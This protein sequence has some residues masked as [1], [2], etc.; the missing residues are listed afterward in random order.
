MNYRHIYH[1]GNFADVFKHWILTCVLQKILE[2]ETPCC[3]IDTHAGIGWYDT[4]S[5]E[6]QKTQEA[7]HGVNKILQQSQVADQFLDYLNIVKTY[8]QQYNA[9]PGSPAI[10]QEF[11][12]GSDRLL[13]NEMHAE[14]YATLKA[15][16]AMNRQI[17]IF[18]QD[19]Y[20]TLKAILPPIE[21]RAVIFIDPPFEKTNEWDLIIQG[22]KQ[23]L[24][25]FANGIYM[26]WYPIKDRNVVNKFYKNIHN[27]A[28]AKVLCVELHLNENIG[29][30]LTACGL[31]IFNTP[32]QLKETLNEYMPKLLKYLQ[33]QNAR[34]SLAD[35]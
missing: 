6:A 10:M 16:F 1:A 3:L 14:D 34:F 19:A 35:L 15:N 17:K 13:L 31:I 27:L 8:A 5:P 20:A 9:Y 18:N 23:A 29:S 21:R 33:F 11:L 7:Q 25:R 12:R 30:Q 26:I 32:W 4:S 2:K 28:V 22:L 24:K